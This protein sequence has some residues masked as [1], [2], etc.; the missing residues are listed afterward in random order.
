MFQPFLFY[1]QLLHYYTGMFIL[2]VRIHMST[3]YINMDLHTALYLVAISSFNVHL[4]SL[5]RKS[6][7]TGRQRRLCASELVLCQID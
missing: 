7:V 5:L 3:L 2:L 6:L 4:V 1:I